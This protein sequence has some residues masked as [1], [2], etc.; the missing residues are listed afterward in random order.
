MIEQAEA[1]VHLVIG[2]YFRPTKTFSEFRELMN[3]HSV[4][5]LRAFS[6][7]C[8]SELQAPNDR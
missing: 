3:G 1:V 4:N 5:P 7:K 2:T 6:E 8:W